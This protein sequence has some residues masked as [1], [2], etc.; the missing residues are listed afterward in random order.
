MKSPNSGVMAGVIP[1]GIAQAL[2]IC[3]A[4]KTSIWHQTETGS[5]LGISATGLVIP[6]VR[7]FLNHYPL[8][9]VPIRIQCISRLHGHFSS[10]DVNH[11]EYLVAHSGLSVT[12]GNP[13]TPWSP[14][15]SNSFEAESVTRLDMRSVPGGICPKSRYVFDWLA[16]VGCTSECRIQILE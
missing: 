7:H 9:P 15:R 12:S 1:T 2:V 6:V 14:G 10:R 4:P 3:V 16:Y 5:I 8:P 13:S 11:E